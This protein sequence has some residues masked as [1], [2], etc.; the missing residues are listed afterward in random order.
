M[1]ESIL[2]IVN[3][4]LSPNEDCFDLILKC[5]LNKRLQMEWFITHVIVIAWNE[6]CRA[7]H[8]FYWKLK[9]AFLKEKSQEKLVL[10]WFACQNS[11]AKQSAIQ[12][13]FGGKM[14]QDYCLFTQHQNFK[15]WNML[16][17][18]AQNSNNSAFFEMRRIP[19]ILHTRSAMIF[20]L[21]LLYIL[22]SIKIYIILRFHFNW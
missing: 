15:I 7:V 10:K 21:W 17:R 4:Q 22:I 9:L 1:E 3:L 18:T 12:T 14:H 20:N 19:F 6:S 13:I 5:K 11:I 2:S 8:D 16:A